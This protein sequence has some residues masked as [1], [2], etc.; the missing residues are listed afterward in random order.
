[1]LLFTTPNKFFSDVW[2]KVFAADDGL[3]DPFLMT[4][5]SKDEEGP[6]LQ[7]SPTARQSLTK[8]TSNLEVGL[9]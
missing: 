1:M 9:A 3:E 7:E 2:E 8:I 4:Y 5:V 6:S